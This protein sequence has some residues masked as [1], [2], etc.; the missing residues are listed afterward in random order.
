MLASAVPG[1]TIH[2]AASWRVDKFVEFFGL[3]LDSMS[4][5]R[6]RATPAQH[7]RP[8]RRDMGFFPV[9]LPDPALHRLTG[10]P[11]DV[12]RTTEAYCREQGPSSVI[13]P[14]PDPEYTKYSSWTSIPSLPSMAGPKRPQDR[15]SDIRDEGSLFKKAL[16]APVSERACGA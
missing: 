4:L 7:A 16:T 8:T 15:G 2:A 14:H 1:A 6:D 5:A 12:N 3:G 11:Q 9:D 10:R 13:R